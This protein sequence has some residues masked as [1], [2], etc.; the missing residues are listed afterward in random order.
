MGVVTD[1]GID[2]SYRKR[3]EKPCGRMTRPLSRIMSDALSGQ[4]T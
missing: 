4:S 3:E 2:N 1:T